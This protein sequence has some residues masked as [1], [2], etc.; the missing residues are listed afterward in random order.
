MPQL[1]RIFKRKSNVD[2]K[3]NKRVND[4]STD[5]PVPPVP[6]LPGTI[7]RQLTLPVLQLTTS[8]VDQSDFDVVSAPAISYA[9]G[10]SSQ[11]P[12]GDVPALD[13]SPQVLAD[14]EAQI[15]SGVNSD[16]TTKGEKILNKVSAVAGEY[17]FH[18]HPFKNILIQFSDSFTR[19]NEQL[20]AF[21]A[22]E[23]S[24]Y[25]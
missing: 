15:W 22:A 24:S 19:L 9:P 23:G 10:T 21:K 18:S 11:Q 17:Y 13:G 1:S 16:P 20:R 14:K 8:P 12:R 2:L 25:R 6:P 3:S 5:E 4:A 7:T